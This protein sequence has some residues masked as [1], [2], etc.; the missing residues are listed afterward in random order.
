MTRRLLVAATAALLL[1]A[2]APSARQAPDTQPAADRDAAFAAFLA[3]VRTDARQQG[4]AEAT[5]DRAF[6]G[7]ALEPVVVSRDRTQPETV[8]SLD[9]Y[10]A[11]RVTRRTIAT[12][13]TMAVRHRR[14]LASVEAR[15]GIPSEMMVAIWGLES[16]F[17]RFT[18]T[19]PTIQALATLAF[20]N[21]RALFRTE[22]L[23]ALH[24]LDRG[25][26]APDVLKGSWAGAMG[27]PQFMP[28]SFLAHAVDFDEDGRIDIWTS[29][30]DVFGSMGNY[31]HD[32]GWT[33]GERWGRE[34]RVPRE[35][36]DRIDERVPMRSASCRALREMTEP[37]PLGDWQAL[38]VR[39]TTGAALPHSDM[40]ASLVRGVRRHFLVYRNYEA[41]IDY[42]CS[43]SYALSAALIAEGM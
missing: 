36:L 29:T 31:L 13:R 17:G 3:G 4:I 30:A 6:A 15:Y 23:Q 35:V 5:L 38:G 27:Q 16:N 40:E 37:R 33:A 39:L 42:N 12:A 26:V 2:V 7:V 34:V 9:E 41:I 25:L 19:Y 28:S 43:N 14:V 10:L 18:G 21:R 22:L 11:R 32:A 1:S 24:I 8:L 20:D